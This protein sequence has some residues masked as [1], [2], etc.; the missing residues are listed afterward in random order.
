[1]GGSKRDAPTEKGLAAVSINSLAQDSGAGGQTHAASNAC[2]D[3][4]PAG[5]GNNLGNP[6][7]GLSQDQ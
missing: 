7:P 3:G 1:M 4:E 2:V 5:I 6:I